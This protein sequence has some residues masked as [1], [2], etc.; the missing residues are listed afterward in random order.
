MIRSDGISITAD[1]PRFLVCLLISHRF[2][3]EEWGVPCVNTKTPGNNGFEKHPDRNIKK[4]MSPS[5][6][7]TKL[8][9]DE[10]D[11]VRI[12]RVSL[13][14]SEPSPL[15]YLP[16]LHFSGR[17]QAGNT[18]CAQ[19]ILGI[20]GKGYRTF[21]MTMLEEL[22]PLASETGTSFINAWLDAV[23]CSFKLIFR[24]STSVTN[25]LFSFIRPRLSLETRCRTW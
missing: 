22:V 20:W 7:E 2:N 3:V 15:K 13:Y 21:R 5:H 6:E 24:P 12:D 25:D 10:V 1:F 14:A 17:L 23:A 9:S 16:E 18:L 8:P 11:T 4:A 19:S